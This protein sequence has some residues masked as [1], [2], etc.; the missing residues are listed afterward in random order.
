MSV[1]GYTLLK[2]LWEHFSLTLDGSEHAD[3]ANS[4][5]AKVLTQLTVFSG[6]EETSV[7]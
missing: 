6:Q 3:A 2:V 1:M 4:T 5:L 7:R